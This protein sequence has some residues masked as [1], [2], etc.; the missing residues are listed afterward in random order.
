MKCFLAAALFL[1]I[2]LMPACAA[3]KAAAQ[4]ESDRRAF[5]AFT[6]E[7]SLKV[8]SLSFSLLSGTVALKG[9]YQGRVKKALNECDRFLSE[10]SKSIPLRS[11]TNLKRLREVYADLRAIAEEL[12][13]MDEMERENISH[14]A[15]NADKVQELEKSVTHSMKAHGRESASGALFVPLEEAMG[16]LSSATLLYVRT[17]REEFRKKAEKARSDVKERLEEWVKASAG[18]GIDE[19]AVKDFQAV[20]MEFQRS[21]QDAMDDHDITLE[22]IGRFADTMLLFDSLVEV[23]GT[24]P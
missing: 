11:Q 10:A 4:A 5:A 20:V 18:A 15:K 21:A 7:F 14:H 22:R 24:R 3:G 12:A 8:H 13:D 19:K 1:I 17:G 23:Y 9:S 16:S 6:R 2:A